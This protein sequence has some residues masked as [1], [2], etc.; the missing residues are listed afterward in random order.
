MNFMIHKIV[1]VGL[2]LFL[3]MAMVPLM[4]QEKP[5]T[6]PTERV[7]YIPYQQLEKL[8]QKTETGIYLPYKDYQKLMEEVDR[9]RKQPPELPVLVM[10]SNVNYQ[11]RV[12]GDFLEIVASY[13]LNVLQK[14]W[15]GVT[16][17]FRNIAIKDAQLDGK[18]ALLQ[19]K[20]EG[21]ELV[22]ESSEPGKRQ[23][24]V[25]MVVALVKTL[26]FRST[27]QFYIPRAPIARLSL[28]IPTAKE[29]EGQGAKLKIDVYPS[30]LTKQTFTPGIAKIEALLGN[31]D[32]VRVQW[33]SQAERKVEIKQI[34]HAENI[35][36]LEIG[37][38]FL[39]LRAKIRYDLIQ[40]DIQKLQ[41]KI[42]QGFRVLGVSSVQGVAVRDWNVAEQEAQLVVN[43][44][45]KLTDR[46]ENQVDLELEL[47]LEK[48][49]PEMEKKFA[50]PSLEVVG[51]ER[52]KGFYT[53]SVNDLN[54]IKIVQRKDITQ[55][56]IPDLP[57]EVDRQG[58][59]FAFKYLKRPF[60]LE[61]E[62]EKIE[63]E[64]EV[65]TNVYGYLDESL[66]KLY[67]YFQ[68]QVKKSRIFGSKIEIPQGFLLFDVKAY[69][70]AESDS[71]DQIKEYRELDEE[72]NQEKKHF[73]SITFKKGIRSE[74][75]MLKIH[76]QR[77]LD[78]Q[79]KVREVPLPVFR[80][81]GAAREMGN[82]GL[83]V[84]ASYN[85]TTLDKSTKNVTPLDTSELFLQGERP[86]REFIK[87]VNIGVR[88][89]DHPIAARFKIEKRDPLVTA[90]IYNYVTVEEKT[91]KNRFRILYTVKYTGVK[92]FSFTLPE[93]IAKDVPKSHVSDKNKWIKQI[94]IEEQ[95]EAKTCLYTIATQRDIVKQEDKD[96]PYEIFVD[97]QKDIPAVNASQ[98]IPIFALITQNT[99][100]E[101]GFIVFKKNNNFSMS[102]PP[103][104]MKGLE[105]ADVQDPNYHG[106]KDGVLAI[107]KYNAHPYLLT[108]EMQ[109]LEFEPV[110][111][112]VIN[113][114][115]LS[116]TVNKDFTTRN[117]AVVL[118]VNNSKQMLDFEVPEASKVTSVSRLRNV[119]A[120]AQRQELDSYLESL[121]WSKSEENK[122]E[123][124]A[125]NEEKKNR[126]RVNIATNVQK[127]APF[128]LVIKYEGKIGEGQMGTSGKLHM[129]PLSFASDVP[130]SYFRWD[131]GLPYDYQ[132]V[133]FK[134]TLI[135]RYSYDDYGI[136][137]SLAPIFHSGNVDTTQIKQD[138][139]TGVI[140][141]YDIQGK[142][143][144]F[145]RLNSG[146]TIRVSYMEDNLLYS[147]ELLL[148]IIVC[149]IMV[150]LPRTQTV[151]RLHVFLTLLVFALFLSAFSLQGYM[152]LYLTILWATLLSGGTAIVIH[153][154]KLVGE[155]W[156]SIK[157]TIPNRLVREQKPAATEPAE[158]EVKKE[159]VAK[160]EAKTQEHGEEKK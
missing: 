125:K 69:N 121:T 101:H 154:G 51:V 4:A 130:V 37:E 157:A 149:V 54:T 116:T 12:V 107:F 136:W 52:E 8:I 75:L 5:E 128:V 10:I 38:N 122:S 22:F 160:D 61:L 13:T 106:E 64:Y 156:S 120:Y 21:Y 144:S 70:R 110:L 68:Y 9:A 80:V 7:I 148:F 15:H 98:K 32:E 81:E 30:L 87:T 102:F 41:V 146:G 88:Y 134:S 79:E 71:V 103:E 147:L 11:G 104:Y 34:L 46:G 92:E 42:P 55:I 158:K 133:R 48:I 145:N 17:G 72:V 27:A 108:M 132:Y 62:L 26:G 99:K 140:P 58:V 40:G 155:K 138:A 142:L 53:V 76:L 39:Q 1:S 59:Q 65:F 94:N 56:D 74:R 36:R 49:F 28:E 85:I 95:K 18:P 153:W 109:R 73:L 35:T 82:V 93:D 20:N 3:I 44:V 91:L 16:L 24:D 114:L 100:Q 86:P 152:Q 14:G 89:F 126:Y 23:L 113:R 124:K 112:T 31:T 67:A 143:F 137:G 33:E 29:E 135:R 19:W 127:N 96:E 141:T 50:I 117:E 63:P 66:Y 111:N 83:G 151:S 57:P 150:F 118:V 131:L 84:H 129:T 47:K 139:E 115:H 97:Y 43:L 90:E 2:L 77:K 105:T 45:D 159:P 6:L 123:D 119:N 60:S 78:L 25:T